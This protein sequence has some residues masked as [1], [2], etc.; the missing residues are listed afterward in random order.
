[1]KRTT[2]HIP[3]QVREWIVIVEGRKYTFQNKE[4]ADKFLKEV[5]EFFKHQAE[6]FDKHFPEY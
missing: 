1:M 3:E 6:M 5:E 2:K 4:A